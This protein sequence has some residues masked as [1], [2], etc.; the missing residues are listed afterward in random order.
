MS[1]LHLLTQGNLVSVTFPCGH[2]A[3]GNVW[4]FGIAPVHAASGAN[5]MTLTLGRTP[6]TFD[7]NMLTNLVV[8]PHT[9]NDRL[10]NF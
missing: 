6:Y 3:V 2:N 1:N 8:E 5:I 7:A 10:F 4:F 9:L